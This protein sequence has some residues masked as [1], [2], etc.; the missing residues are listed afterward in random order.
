MTT[1]QSILQEREKQYGSFIKVAAMSQSLKAVLFADNPTLQ[2]HQKEA[3]EMICTKLARICAGNNP[4]YPDS[5][6]DIAGYA[7]LANTVVI[8]ETLLEQI[9]EQN[10]TM[11]HQHNQ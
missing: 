7:E 2:P 1:T 3:I 9:G 11:C 8:S 6:V 4:N 10:G 5:W